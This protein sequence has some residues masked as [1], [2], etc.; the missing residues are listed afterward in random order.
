MLSV[1]LSPITNGFVFCSYT[2]ITDNKSLSDQDVTVFH[3]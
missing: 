3:G 1:E 2:M